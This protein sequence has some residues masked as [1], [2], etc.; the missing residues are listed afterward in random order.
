MLPADELHEIRARIR[1]LQ[2]REAALKALMV[3]DPG[4]P[5]CRG[6]TWEAVVQ[7]RRARRFDVSRLPEAVREAPLF[8]RGSVRRAVL[9]R[10][11]MA[12]A[13]AA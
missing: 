3:A 5:A 12:A 7:T 1:A 13:R 11:S 2:A 10:P 8:H 6:R 4:G 9:L